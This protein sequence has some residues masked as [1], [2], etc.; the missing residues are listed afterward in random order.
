MI[1]LAGR[2]PRSAGVAGFTLMETLVMLMLVSMATTLM[3]QML[4]SYRIAQQRIAVQAGNQDRSSLF[5]SWF[6][7]E[8]HG[9]SAIPGQPFKG[10][11]GEFEGVT[12]NPLFGSPGA[13][14]SIRWRLSSSADGGVIE[15]WEDGQ[16]RWT[17]PLRDFAGARFV[18]FAKDGTQHDQWPP[19]KGLQE[20]LPAAIAFVRGGPQAERMRLAAVRGPLTPTDVPFEL[21]QE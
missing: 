11:R 5:E 3:F 6:I 12:L 19:A 16:E 9:L 21:E 1:R 4:D 17:L 10:S 2:L 15:Y 7:D 8:V 18:F 13:P 14:S 20:G